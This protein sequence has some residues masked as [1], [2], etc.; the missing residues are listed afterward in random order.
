VLQGIKYKTHRWTE[1]E[2][3]MMACKEIIFWKVLKCKAP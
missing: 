3:V 1:I 2:T